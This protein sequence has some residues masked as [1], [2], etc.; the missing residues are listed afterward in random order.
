[1]ASHVGAFRAARVGQGTLALPVRIQTEDR[2]RTAAIV[3]TDFA[4]FSAIKA[5]TSH[6]IKTVSEGLAC[7]K[8]MHERLDAVVALSDRY[9]KT[10]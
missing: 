3:I 4:R 8:C 1:M 9:C 6:S 2:P 10:A 7:A 5:D